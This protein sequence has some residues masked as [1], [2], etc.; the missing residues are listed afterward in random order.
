MEIN[1]L[2]ARDKVSLQEISTQTQFTIDTLEKH[3]KNHWLIAPKEKKILD[4]ME[5]SSEEANLLV[6]RIME[7]DA[8]IFSGSQAVLESKIQRLHPIQQRLKVLSDKLECD[9]LDD[10]EKQEYILLHRLANDIENS[11]TKI[12]QIIHEQLFPVKREE[13]SRAILNYK[14]S[15][16][17]KLIDQIILVFLEFESKPEYK[18]LIAD[19]RLELAQ[20]IN[21][22]EENILRSGTLLTLS[23]NSPVDSSDTSN[24]SPESTVE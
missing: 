5:N 3:F 19:L 23:S 10:T 15:V 12:Q 11:I 17:Q 18:V 16:L 13:L 6:E 21:A 4:L 7:G 24:P 2:R 1:L 14:L 8:D 9:A 20:R 22:I